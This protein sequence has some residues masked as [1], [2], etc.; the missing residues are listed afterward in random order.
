MLSEDYYRI[1]GLKFQ[2][3]QQ[4]FGHLIHCIPFAKLKLRKHIQF[5]LKTAILRRY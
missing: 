5:T 1:L 2:D 4:K 3:F